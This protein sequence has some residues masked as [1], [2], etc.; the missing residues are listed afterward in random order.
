MPEPSLSVRNKATSFEFGTCVFESQGTV[1]RPAKECLRPNPELASMRA[2]PMSTP[3]DP[4]T[5]S[6][7]V[8]FDFSQWGYGSQSPACTQSS[9]KC[10][11]L[12]VSRL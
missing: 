9:L 3:S 12:I 10:T 4:I 5:H 8:C 11:Y 2:R 7:R 1:H 6:M